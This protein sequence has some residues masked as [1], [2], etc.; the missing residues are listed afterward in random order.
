MSDK[1]VTIKPVEG[2]YI[3]GIPMAV[4]TV[5]EAVAEKLLATA[6]FEKGGSK[7]KQSEFHGEVTVARMAELDAQEQAAE[8]A[9]AAAEEEA[10]AEPD[11]ETE[12]EAEAGDQEEKE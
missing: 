3:T 7:S 2:F 8:E 1:M 10:P 5:P 9:A 6:A 12:P 4:Q 11:A